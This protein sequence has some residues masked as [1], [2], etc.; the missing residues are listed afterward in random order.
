MESKDELERKV[1]MCNQ[2]LER[3]AIQEKERER[4]QTL[5]LPKLALCIG[6]IALLGYVITWFAQWAWGAG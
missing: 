4:R 5:F 6:L 2:A 3:I 1:E